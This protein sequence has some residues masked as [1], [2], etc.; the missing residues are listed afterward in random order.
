MKRIGSPASALGEDPKDKDELGLPMFGIRYARGSSVVDNKSVAK[1]FGYNLDSSSDRDA[2]LLKMREL[3]N[4]RAF[5][6]L[7]DYTEEEGE[8]VHRITAIENIRPNPD[9]KA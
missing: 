4:S 3:V 1:E 2:Y 8:R 7:M 5:E 6:V 9:I